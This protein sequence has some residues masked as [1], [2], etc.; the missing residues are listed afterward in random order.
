MNLLD[1]LN[2][3]QLEAV[4]QTEG[5]VMVMAGAGA[6]KTKVLTSRISYIISELGVLPSS[7]LAVTFTNKAANENEGKSI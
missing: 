7:I 4:K 5:P 3:S 6:G 1:G 2:E